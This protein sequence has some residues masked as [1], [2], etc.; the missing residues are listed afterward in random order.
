MKILVADDSA[1]SRRALESLLSGW[2]YNV[3]V[4]ESGTEAWEILQ[5]A[6]SPRLAILDWM[7]PG[8]SGP[9]VCR[10]VR[11]AMRPYYT[12][13]ILVTSRSEKGD[14]VA[15]VGSGAD[16][17][18]VKPFDAGELRVRL[19]TGMRI[20]RLESEL[21]AAQEALRDQATRDALTKIWN[22]RA[23]LEILERELARCTRE[24]QPLGIVMADVD[25][26]KEVN[27]Q[28]GHLAGDIVLQDVAHRMQ[29]SVRPYDAVGRYGG[30]EFLLVLPGCDRDAVF[31][32]AERI[33]SSLEDTGVGFSG[34]NIS[35][36]ASF[37]VTSVFEC[38]NCSAS[39]VIRTADEALYQAKQRGR[40]CTVYL[41]HASC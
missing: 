15:G 13:L 21:L 11:A 6:D 33:R 12:Y 29:N 5:Q 26:F 17:Y 32:K 35:L 27:D 7:M 22:R 8:M 28:Y 2:G 39:A 24:K 10:Q 19:G 30:E 16:D 23:I 20:L 31:G 1:V 25:H 36:A 40:N 14:V 37:G 34:N 9:D 41:D 18:L 3:I 38:R 4:A